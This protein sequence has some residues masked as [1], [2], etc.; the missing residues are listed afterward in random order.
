MVRK[1]RASDP[2]KRQRR[3][4]APVETRLMAHPRVWQT[5]IKLAEG[6]MTRITVESFAKVTV[7][8]P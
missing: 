3:K 4:P 2:T 1:V 5:A 8:L 6:N 7:V